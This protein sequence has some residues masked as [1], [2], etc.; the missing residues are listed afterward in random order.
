M[1][2]LWFDGKESVAPLELKNIIAKFKKQFNNQDQQDSQEL[3]NVLLDGL[4]EDLNRVKRKPLVPVLESEGNNDLEASKESW[5]NHLKRNQSVV[6]DMMH[7]L[8]K[9][10]VKCPDC[11]CVSVTFE[12][13]MNISLPIPEIKLIQKPFF[14]VPFDPAKRSILYN[15]SIKS[16]KPINH[17]KEFI[18]DAFKVNKHSFDIVLI[19]D[20]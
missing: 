14:W 17:L 10:T 18:G 9:S 2:Q 8:Y 4:H 7:G 12:P 19:Q 5:K 20:D 15:F 16:H 11:N 1:K 13:Y 6:V 3:L